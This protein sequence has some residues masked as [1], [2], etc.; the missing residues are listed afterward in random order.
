M[1]ST[2]SSTA[3][4][5]PGRPAPSGGNGG[6]G[7]PPVTPAQWWALGLASIASFMVILDML[8]VATALT[9]IQRDLH[10]SIADLEW[11]VNA[12]TLSFAVLLMT[13]ASL[14]DRFGRRRLF[15]VGLAVFAL[16][17][18]GCAL[19]PNVGVLVAAR[20][21]Q[22]VGA[23]TIMPL[24]LGLLN[25]AFPPARRGWAIGIYGSVTS[26]AILSGPVLGGA[27]TQGLAWQ[28]IFWLNVPIGLAAIPFV[29]RRLHEGPANRSAAIDVPGLVVFTAAAVGLVWGLVRA[30][31]AGWGSPEVTGA[32]VAGAVLSVAFVR[33]QAR[34]RTP[35]LPLRLFRS[36]SFSAGNLIIFL[37]NATM[38]GAIFFLT[39]YQQVALGQGP[40]DAGLRTLPWGVAP[41]LLA[42]RT[43]ALADRIGERPLI[44]A[45]MV[46]EAASMFW[47]AGSATASASYLAVVAPILLAG[48]GAALAIP[49]VTKSAVNTN[50]PEDI[51]KASGAYSTMRQL[52]GAF[53]VAILS[54]AF[55]A[56]GS[57]A[58]ASDF[59][60][61]LRTALVV[62]G[63]LSLAGA[64]AATAIA[65][66]PRAATAGGEA[67]GNAGEGSSVR[68]AGGDDRI[69][70]DRAPSRTR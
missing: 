32:L 23:A 4:A 3:G 51:G 61:G 55:T 2:E 57:Y 22:G 49:A 14:G 30:D 69:T 43:G 56:S 47:L 15:A 33:R 17:S 59:S 19:A 20:T 27:L 11:T 48:L 62:A 35:M 46:L 38:T 60:D 66:R 63:A 6:E 45:G 31:A 68:S 10:A 25:S 24:A 29:L 67:K 40:L 50:A 26:L 39:Q 1:S 16:A 52:G 8:V 41:F 5:L 34:A 44:A 64:V 7:R 36:R 70:D 21:V 37:L 18:A 9:A 13:S 53:G 58:S 65:P 54:A 42:P 28:W 12:Y